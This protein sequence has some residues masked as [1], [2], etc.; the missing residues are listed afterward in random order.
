MNSHSY[1]PDCN[2]CPSK[3]RRHE[4]LDGFTPHGV[5]S[6]PLLTSPVHRRRATRGR[7]GTEDVLQIP[8][9]G[10]EGVVPAPLQDPPTEVLG[11]LPVTTGSSTGTPTS[12]TSTD[13]V[14]T[15][16]PDPALAKAKTTQTSSCTTSPT[17]SMPPSA[18][19]SSKLSPHLRLF[20][21]IGCAFSQRGHPAHTS[22]STGKQI[23]T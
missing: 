4:R 15:G 10:G 16:T 1:W 17:K 12:T 18:S 21:E 22:I 3:K 19:E 13:N 2:W 8:N 20:P 5:A 14:M 6:P 23:Q 9:V 7:R 11:S